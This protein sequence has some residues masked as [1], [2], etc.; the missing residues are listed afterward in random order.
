[1]AK[2]NGPKTPAGRIRKLTTLL[3][4][5][6]RVVDS[7]ASTIAAMNEMRAVD[8]MAMETMRDQLQQLDPIEVAANNYTNA[9][10]KQPSDQREINAT[11]EELIRVVLAHRRN[12]GLSARNVAPARKQMAFRTMTQVAGS[13]M[14]Q[15]EE[16]LKA[17]D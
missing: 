10:L 12:N 11:Q 15:N 13:D 1:M 4:A 7:H 3:N 17:L 16:A 8:R 14:V 9:V 2:K 6:Q 5:Q